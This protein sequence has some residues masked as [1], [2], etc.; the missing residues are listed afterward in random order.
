LLAD[1]KELGSCEGV[2]VAVP[3]M[4]E[5]ATSRIFHAPTLGWRD[6][7]L[8]EPLAAATG[9]P[10]HLENA[11]R[12]CA[13]A[14]IWTARGE[15]TAVGD[16][17]FLSVSDGLGGAIVSNGELM[18]GRHNVAG[19]FGHLPLNVDGPRCSCG[20]TGC[21]E[22]YVS[23][24]ASV[25]RYLGNTSGPLSPAPSGITVHDVIARAQA[26]DSRAAAA[27]ETTG[28][29]LGLGLAAIVNAV[30]PTRIYVGGEITAV[31]NLLA[32]TVRSAVAERILRAAAE[33]EIVVVPPEEHPRLRGAAILVAAPAFAAPVVA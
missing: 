8:R 33:P 27:L 20:A 13:L 7:R 14:Q 11:A 32:S 2:G 24:I 5:R 22:T 3:G 18:R 12:V 1:H 4:I 10:V 31:W 26:G 15:H 21:W 17:V 29:Y 19:E 25:S 30:D 23:N 6:V 28:R 9:L 16:L